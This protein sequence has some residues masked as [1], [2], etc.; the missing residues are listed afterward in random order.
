MISNI[1][2]SVSYLTLEPVSKENILYVEIDGSMIPTRKNDEPWKEVKFGRL[3]RD[4]DCLNPKSDVS[5]LLA[6]QYVVHLGNST[7][8]CKK[9]GRVIDAYGE[10]K[11]RLVFIN[12]GTTWI[13]EWITDNYWHSIF[14]N[15]QKQQNDKNH[16]HINKYPKP[17][18]NFRYR[19]IGHVLNPLI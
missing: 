8:F 15:I 17:V 5:Y 2:I 16:F 3:F 18:S 11:D 6:S 1:Q 19:I 9:L 7:D 10:L 4:V 14:L 13:R 12:D